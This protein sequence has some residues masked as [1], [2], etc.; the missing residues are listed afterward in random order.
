MPTGL[1]GPEKP[2]G[3]DWEEIVGRSASTLTAPRALYTPKKVRPR[4]RIAV[5]LDE[6]GMPGKEIAQSLGYT[7]GRL[8]IILT[9]R[10]PELLELRKNFAATVG[11]RCMDVAQRIHLFANEALDVMIF[12]AREKTA[13]R[14]N[15]RQASRD[16]LH[17]A[18][19]SPVKKSLALEAQIPADD[20]KELLGHIEEANKV[21]AHYPGV[22]V[23]ERTSTDRKGPV[24]E[25]PSG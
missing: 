24:G 12:H 25:L 3:L 19:F 7:Q 1:P 2:I 8:S 5:M 17:M 4:H 18:G 20:M 9:S 22:E 6:A 13:D 14:G 23:H 11:D 15:S 21:I 16:L 10:N